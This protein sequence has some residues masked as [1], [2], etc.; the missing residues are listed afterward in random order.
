MISPDF[1]RVERGEM[2]PPWVDQR[3]LDFERLRKLLVDGLVFG[4]VNVRVPNDTIDQVTVHKR[5]AATEMG[6]DSM[7]CKDLADRLRKEG[8]KQK[9]KVI[10]VSKAWKNR[11]H[12]TNRYEVPPPIILPMLME[13]ED[14]EDMMMARTNTKLFLG[15]LK[16]HPIERMQRAFASGASGDPQEIEDDEEIQEGRLS[17]QLQEGFEA[18]FGIAYLPY[19]IIDVVSHDRF[20]S[21]VK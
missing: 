16:E 13:S 12:L 5:L 1:S 10:D 17:P 3:Q 14:F 6:S 19:A 20:P 15:M 4:N 9:G 18:L 8:A 2:L 11:Q 7:R 21:W